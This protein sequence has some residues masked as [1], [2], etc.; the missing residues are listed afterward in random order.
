M[1][2]ATFS[3]MYHYVALSISIEQM[4]KFTLLYIPVADVRDSNFPT[5][6]LS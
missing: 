3:C 4:N 5:Q 1:A 2:E 6:A